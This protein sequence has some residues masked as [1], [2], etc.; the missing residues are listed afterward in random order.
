M[1]PKRRRA[2]NEPATDARA[3]I[4]V[5]VLVIVM[6]MIADS[7][8]I[9]LVEAEAEAETVKYPDRRLR[10]EDPEAFEVEVR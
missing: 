9:V 5:R 6:I 2:R 3:V 1:D 7:E 10:K 8:C 4:R